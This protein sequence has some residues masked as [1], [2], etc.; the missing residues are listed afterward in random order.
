MQYWPASK[1]IVETYGRISV[2]IV[3]EEELAHFH[4]R[5]FKLTKKDLDVSRVRNISKPSTR[6]RTV[7]ISE[8]SG[9]AQYIAVPLHRMAQPLVPISQCHSGV[10][11]AG[12]G[13][14]RPPNQVERARAHGRA[15]QVSLRSKPG[16]RL[17]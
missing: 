12:A 17:R 16:V 8:R 10:Q 3:Y 5:T 4:I 14:G 15:L 9:R 13:R 2:S 6:T 11:A 1:E 7:C